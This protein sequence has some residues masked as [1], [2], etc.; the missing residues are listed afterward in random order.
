MIATQK[1]IEQVLMLVN[2]PIPEINTTLLSEDTRH[3]SV[4]IHDLLGDAVLFVQNNKVYGA[5]NPKVYDVPQIAITDNGDGSGAIVVPADFVN[6]VELQLDGW[7]RSCTRLEPSASPLALAQGNIYTRGG[8]CKPVCVD[9][10]N[11]AGERVIDYYSLPKEK[12]PAVKKFIY[13]AVF[14]PQAG[15]SCAEGNP[16]VPAVAYQCTSLLYNVF[17]RRDAAEAFMTLALSCCRNGNKE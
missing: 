1:L 7:A 5:I 4:T 3:L 9:G 17:D 6:L 16:L 14:E 11:N 13:E 15:L 10:V 8:C 2:E 12:T